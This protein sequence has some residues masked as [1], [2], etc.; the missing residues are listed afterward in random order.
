[1]EVFIF[2][3][4]K[5]RNKREEEDNRKKKEICMYVLINIC[6]EVKYENYNIIL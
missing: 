5:K 2:F 1:M 4:K 6:R 3:Y